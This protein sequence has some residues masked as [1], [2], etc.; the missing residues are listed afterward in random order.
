MILVDSHCHL[1]FA[2]LQQNLDNFI[3][4]AQA[5]NVDYLQTICTKISQFDNIKNIAE[6]YHNIFCSVGVHPNEVLAEGIYK[7]EQI[8]ALSKYKKL[9]AIGETGLDY[10]YENSPKLVQQESFIEHIKASQATNLPIIIHS[11]DA[12]ED[13][14]NILYD[15]MKIAEFPILIHCFTASADF[16]KKIL[17]LGG[18]ISISGIVTFKNAKGLQEIVK[19]IPL[20]KLLIETDSP[21]LAPVPKRGKTNQPAYVKYVA[22]FLAEHLDIK[23]EVLAE[24]TTNNFFNLFSKAQR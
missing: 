18:Y 10:Y 15:Q 17:D 3:K 5:N 13:S 19:K 20:D 11:R 1:D 24:K 4:D 12:E 9:I 22:E 21:Y 2:E 6:K 7:A 16:A 8:I 23:L 14:Y